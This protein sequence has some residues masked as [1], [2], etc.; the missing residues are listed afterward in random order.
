MLFSRWPLCCR[1]ID[2]LYAVEIAYVFV[3]GLYAVEI[4]L[5]FML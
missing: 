3:A 1:D 5:A 2:G 4:L